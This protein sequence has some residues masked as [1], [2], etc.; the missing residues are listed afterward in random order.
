MIYHLSYMSPITH[1]NT[2][3][4]T[5]DLALAMARVNSQTVGMSCPSADGRLYAGPTRNSFLICSA[6]TFVHRSCPQGTYFSVKDQNC[7][8]AETEGVGSDD[9]RVIRVPSGQPVYYYP[10]AQSQP[11]YTQQAPL[12]PNGYQY[13]MS[14]QPVPSEYAGLAQL[15]PNRAS[16][17]PVNMDEYWKKS[18]TERFTFQ[19]ADGCTEGGSCSLTDP[20]T[21]KFCPVSGD[22]SYYM[23]CAPS[24][25]ANG[26]WRKMRC[27]QNSYFYKYRCFSK[28]ELQ[29]QYQITP[30]GSNPGPVYT[31][32][33]MP[34]QPQQPQQILQPQPQPQPVGPAV[35][36]PAIQGISQQQYQQQQMQLQQYQ[37]QLQQLQ[38]QVQQQSQVPPQPQP[39]PVAPQPQVIQQPQPMGNPQPYPQPSYPQYISQAQPQPQPQPQMVVD[40][41][42]QYGQPLLPY[43]TAQQPSSQANYNPYGQY[44]M[45]QITAV[46]QGS[47]QPYP[48]PQFAASPNGAGSFQFT[49]YPG[50]SG[51][52]EFSLKQDT[53]GRWSVLNG[54]ERPSAR[55][56]NAI[57]FDPV[58]NKYYFTGA[59]GGIQS[60]YDLPTSQQLLTNKRFVRA[61]RHAMS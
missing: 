50:Q 15:P 59:Q 13:Q 12:D 35:Q 3:H 7:V 28:E 61:K 16:V 17:P 40:P 57:A 22:Q 39:Q 6:N 14:Q 5:A 54:A 41:S 10:Q 42:Q 4:N 31:Q 45:P 2:L 37:L 27:A 19:L 44:P 47:Q 52:A 38:Q 1:N 9:G 49:V 25:E 48:A 20:T 24:S 18:W 36:Q 43:Q 8:T 26:I 46:P 23:Q 21:L 58:L 11:Q 55:P 30:V 60:S 56:V 51:P 32:P 53:R 34:Q 29:Q 33:Q